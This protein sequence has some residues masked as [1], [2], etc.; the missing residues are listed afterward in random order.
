MA[1]HEYLIHTGEKTR[2]NRRIIPGVWLIGAGI[3]GF[4]H[5]PSNQS[6]QPSGNR[7]R[8]SPS[9]TIF[10][11]WSCDRLASSC[12]DNVHCIRFSMKHLAMRND[13]QVPVQHLQ[14]Y[15]VVNLLFIL[16]FC[17]TIHIA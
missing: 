17:I 7:R 15:P 11:I 9:G 3:P 10:I 14:T 2:A 13:C 12:F 8:V 1:R 16:F 6:I 4:L 5:I